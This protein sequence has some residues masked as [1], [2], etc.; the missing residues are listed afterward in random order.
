M[1]APVGFQTRA[2]TSGAGLQR[3]SKAA[4]RRQCQRYQTRTEAGHGARIRACSSL[5][6]KKKLSPPP[7]RSDLQLLYKIA[8]ACSASREVAAWS[9]WPDP[10][11]SPLLRPHSPSVTDAV[12]FG[13]LTGRQLDLQYQVSPTCDGP[14]AAPRQRLGPALTPVDAAPRRLPLREDRYSTWGDARYFSGSAQPRFKVGMLSICPWT[15][16]AGLQVEP[17]DLPGYHASGL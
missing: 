5:V 13:R 4:A 6:F 15:C 8:S 12:L 16:W 2:A 14:M 7:A 3:R 9:R 17:C 1:K 11:P 10:P